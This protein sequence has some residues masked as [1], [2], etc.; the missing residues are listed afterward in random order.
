M[1]LSKIIQQGYSNSRNGFRKNNS[2]VY[3]K[4]SFYNRKN[5]RFYSNEVK[6]NQSE[7]VVRSNLFSIS[8]SINFFLIFIINLGTWNYIK[9]RNF[10]YGVGGTILVGLALISEISEMRMN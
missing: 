5:K 6:E 3:S 4:K 7:G 2:S 10:R 8:I 9:Q 1:S